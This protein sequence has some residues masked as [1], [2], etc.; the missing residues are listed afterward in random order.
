MGRVL[1]T[2]SHTCRCDGP[3]DADAAEMEGLQEDWLRQQLRDFLNCKRPDIFPH[4][5]YWQG[6]MFETWRKGVEEWS[7]C[8]SFAAKNGQHCR[9][10]NT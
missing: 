2:C 4:T 9:L 3:A 7:L 1:A 8:E 5:S 6:I 10:Y